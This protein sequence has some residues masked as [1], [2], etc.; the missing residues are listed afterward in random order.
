MVLLVNNSYVYLHLCAEKVKQQRVV[1]L[2]SELKHFTSYIENKA[3]TE[4][5][6]LKQTFLLAFNS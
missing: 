4:T 3:V 2:E 1:F 6:E 5:H